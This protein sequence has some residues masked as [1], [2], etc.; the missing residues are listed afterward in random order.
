MKIYSIFLILLRNNIFFNILLRKVKP[1]HTA[2]QLLEW[3]NS[4]RETILTISKDVE[5]SEPFYITGENIK[6]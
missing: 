5:K 1:W 3:I 2:T 4:I 6:A